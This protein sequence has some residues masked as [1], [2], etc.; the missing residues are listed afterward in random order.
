MKNNYRL[1]SIFV[2]LLLPF[3]ILQAQT[4][5]ISRV[6]TTINLSNAG[7]SLQ[8]NQKQLR[9][10]PF[11]NLSSY[12][13]I[14][15]S[16]YRLKG[17]RMFYFGIEASRNHVFIDGMQVSDASGFPV[18]LI[19]K[20]NLYTA[21]TPINMGFAT[22]GITSIETIGQQKDFTFLLDAGTD[23]AY[24]MQSVHGEFFLSVPLISK[25]R[26]KNR[27]LIPSLL[28]A[29]KYRWTNNNDPVW[30]KTQRLKSDVL[31]ELYA[32]PLR[33]DESWGSTELNALNVTT[34]DFTKQKVP[35]YNGSNGIFPFVKLELPVSGNAMLTLGNYSA[36]EQ[37]DV[38]NFDNYLFNAQGNALKTQ[39]NFDTYIKWNQQFEIKKDFT[40]SYNLLLQYTNHYYKTEDRL[41][42][43][44]FFDY[45]YLG[46]FTTYKNPIYELRDY[47]I[48]SITYNNV[49]VLNTW[50]WDT[51]VQ[52][53]PMGQYP[54]LSNYTSNYY[55]I[56]S[57][58]PAG[59]YENFDQIMLNGGLL[60]GDR[61]N[62][63][64]GM[65]NNTATNAGYYR[66]NS[67]EKI[68]GVFQVNI[69][70]HS[71]NFTIG[72]EYNRETQ[73]H[74][75]IEPVKL[76]YLMRALT[77]FHFLE[78]DYSN[79]ILVKHD[80]KLDT[81]NFYRKYDVGH[82]ETFDKNLRK[83][84]GLPVDGVDYIMTDSYDRV[85]NTISY[86]D[87]DGVMHTIKTPG[88]LWNLN[89]FSADELL[90]DG[91]PYVD[92]AGYN[93]TGAKQQGKGNPYAFYNNRTI[94]PEQPEYWS[95][96]F[97]DKFKWKKLHVRLGLRLDVY[98]ANHPEMNDPYS[99]F[100]INNVSE[101]KEQNTLEFRKP[102]TIGDDYLVYVDNT[103]NPHKVTGFRKDDRWFDADGRE[104]EDP[105]ILDT[106]SGISPWLKYPE[107]YRV[108]GD[109]WTPDMTFRNYQTAFNLL[110][111]IALDYSVTQ[112]FNVY[113]NYSSFSQNPSYFSAFKPQEFYY[114]EAYTGSKF[115]SNSGLQPMVTSKLF[116]GVKGI[117]W[118]S[119]VVDVS[120]LMTAMKNYFKPKVFIGA[121]PY[122]YFTMVNAKKSISTNGFMAKADFV[123][124]GITGPFGGMNFTKLFPNESDANYYQ[125]TDAVFNSYLGYRFADGDRGKKHSGL[126]GLSAAV[127]Y[128]HRRG[129]PYYYYNN[130][131]KV[132]GRTPAVNLINLNLQKDFMVGKKAAMN[133]YLTV[134][135]LFNIKNVFNVYPETGQ[136]DD[137]GFL[138]DPENQAYINNQIN[139]DT[140]RLLYQMH[141]YN[142]AYYDIPSIWR[143]GLIFKW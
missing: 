113:V 135:N 43:N 109:G 38:Y 95:G 129:T 74:Y 71:Q 28:V 59:H 10:L 139:P 34:N 72:G 121:Y 55:D 60:N 131:I 97:N 105:S 130:N 44:N 36:I 94:A 52:F 116:A 35:D 83:A 40:I 141:L 15:P 96:F 41:L 22:G 79:P 42:K 118:K 23:L 89:L 45:G 110:P 6:D 90:N 98:N 100:P 57:G 63:V 50:D 51:L 132:L 46:S 93:Y 21:Q 106:G 2:F 67:M 70:Y 127:Y 16:A 14:S 103:F 112:R 24:N 39:R 53:N 26:R 30:N 126:N 5:T 108:G 47:T 107:I 134:E 29:G 12:G 80:G 124:P 81:I 20:Y 11:L 25:K 86:Y 123:N 91:N 115:I 69:N 49:W 102:A 8:L 31:E 19:R 119:L 75:S 56:F 117:V 99:L 13:L 48:D 32:K 62:S 3:T 138:S 137:D 18:R 128:Q 4:D 142:P 87:K 114:W 58:H 37:K 54:E 9:N 133:V 111:Q 104:L 27:K 143:L 64:Y 76:W 61:P 125:I 66:E 82:Q 78:L 7:S 77:N 92:Y 84:L 140:F 122:A 88:N 17:G 136:A 68:R 65:W 101:A 85:N 33:K 1:F 73:R 120:Y